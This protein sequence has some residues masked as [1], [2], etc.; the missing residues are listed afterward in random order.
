MA[1]Q[2]RTYRQRSRL[3]VDVREGRVVVIVHGVLADLQGIA[4]A[5]RREAVKVSEAR[6]GKARQGKAR[7]G[8]AR[9]EMERQ[10]SENRGNNKRSSSK[11]STILTRQDLADRTSPQ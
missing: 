2:R 8:K 1:T 6:Q 11:S 4:R 7:Q 10:A 9:H 3:E 5:S